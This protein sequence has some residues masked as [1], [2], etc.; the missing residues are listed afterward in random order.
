MFI[1]FIIYLRAGK[2][3][4]TRRKQLQRFQ[5]ISANQSSRQFTSTKTTEVHVTSETATRVH[6]P[7]D[8]S[9]IG[10]SR[11]NSQVDS[12]RP[13]YSVSVF[14]QQQT[15]RLPASPTFSNTSYYESKEPRGPASELLNSYHIPARRNTAM[16]ANNAAWSYT[17]VAVLFFTAMLV[18]WIPSSA[19]R[20]Y[21]VVNQNQISPPLLFASSFV[22]PLQG[23]WNSVIYFTTSWS[24]VVALFADWG[25]CGRRALRRDGAPISTGVRPQT[26]GGASVGTRAVRRPEDQGRSG[27]NPSTSSMA[28]LAGRP[29]TRE[30]DES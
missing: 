16:E 15:P 3:I 6:R 22:L 10:D 23:F 2:E 17:K 7:I 28:E 29:A 9:D 11:T 26:S 14:T 1:T 19:N 13:A 5:H 24:A 8:L 25:F 18:T 12:D 4:Y 27:K 30:S 21:S 20:L